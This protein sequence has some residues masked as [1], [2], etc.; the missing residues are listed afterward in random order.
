VDK[1]KR[2]PTNLSDEIRRKGAK[3]LDC[4]SY[5][6]PFVRFAVPFFPSVEKAFADLRPFD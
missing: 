6:R 2:S 1:P 3:K 4:S 5:S